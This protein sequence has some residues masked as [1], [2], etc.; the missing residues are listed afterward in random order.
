M[1][2]QDKNF[3]RRG[4]TEGRK[5]KEK[6][7]IILRKLS[8]RIVK[9]ISLLQMIVITFVVTTPLFNFASITTNLK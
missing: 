7:K 5:K 4:K 2:G 6:R 1:Y 3:N 9:A 8:K